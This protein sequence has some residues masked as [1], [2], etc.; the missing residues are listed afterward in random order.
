MM[1]IDEI[2]EKTTIELPM[3]LSLKGAEKLLYYLAEEMPA[4]LIYQILHRKSIYRP[5]RESGRKILKQDGTIVISGS[6]S[7]LEKPFAFDSFQ[8]QASDEDRDTSKLSVIRFN[9]VPGWE[10]SEY[11]PEVIELWG[12]VR[13]KV[14]QYFE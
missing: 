3:P 8:L 6:I 7:N 11:R 14:R 12:Q 2:V 1:S 10:L 9:L 13:K 5:F 4:N